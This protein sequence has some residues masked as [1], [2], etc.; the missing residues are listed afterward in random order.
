MKGLLQWGQ[1]NKMKCPVCNVGQ[2]K[3]LFRGYYND[4]Y[5]CDTCNWDTTKGIL[6]ND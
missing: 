6:V 3:L 4:I 5:K 1:T 2:L